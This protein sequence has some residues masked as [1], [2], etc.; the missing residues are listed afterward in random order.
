MSRNERR[1]FLRHELLKDMALK[2]VRNS[3]YTADD[4]Q[5]SCAELYTSSG[6]IFVLKHGEMSIANQPCF[7]LPL[8]CQSEESVAIFPRAIFDNRRF[9]IDELGVH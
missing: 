1:L 7:G 3:C 2:C 5:A 6:M 4:I 9:T 8:G